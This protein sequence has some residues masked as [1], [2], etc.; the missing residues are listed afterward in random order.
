[1]FGIDDAIAGISNL[2]S[3]G[4][5]A[6]ED[7]HW[8]NKATGAWDDY[9]N[10][11]KQQ[12]ALDPNKAE[13][14]LG[15]TDRSA[16]QDM[17]P[18]ARNQANIATQRLLDTGGGSG[19]DTQSR[20]ALQQAMGQ[21]GAASRAAREAVMQQF[22]QRGT[23]GSG[24]DL[25]ATLAGNQQ[26]YGELAAAGGQ[27]AAAAQQRRLEA[28]TLAS[29]AAQ[30]QQ[31]L[32]Q[33][34]ASALDTLKRFN[35]GARQGVLSA[36][37]GAVQTLGQGYSGQ[38]NAYGGFANNMNSAGNPWAGVAAGAGNLGAGIAKGLS[39][40][41]ATPDGWGGSTWGGIQGASPLTDTVLKQGKSDPTSFDWLNTI[42]G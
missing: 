6:A 12:Y 26:G 14:F 5:K 32:E 41:E 30:Q 11:A 27:A 15:L 3:T 4:I 21:S 24:A 19:L 31:Q 1:M 39:S 42:G 33:Q 35:V 18:G 8:R 16:Y 2:F 20:V 10:Q 29:R 9:I 28:N 34:K 17:D 38:A 7:R 36:Q 22:Q 23:S 40:A 13:S 37:Q 25:A